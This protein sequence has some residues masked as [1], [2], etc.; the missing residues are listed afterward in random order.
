M[1]T[2]FIPYNGNIPKVDS[3]VFIAPNA[4]LIGAITVAADCSIWFG[5]T[6]RAD[7]APINIGAGT[8]IQDGTV[9]HTSRF[10]GGTQIGAGVTIGHNATIHACH[11]Q[12]NAF[13][14]MAATVLDKAIIEPFAYVAAGCLIPPGKVVKSN[15]LWAGVPGKFVRK[16]NDEDIKLI[17][18]SSKHYIYLSRQ[19]GIGS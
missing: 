10:N 1:L 5:C 18:D 7:V 16:L 13:I 11:L 4:Y 14:G 19:Y 17:E 6:L 3:S 9:I 2:N 12:D 8:N 15:E